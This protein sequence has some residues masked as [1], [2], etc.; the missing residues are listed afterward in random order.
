VTA[1]GDDIPPLPE[2]ARVV[3][4]GLS[5]FADAVARQGF[6]VVNVDWRIPADGDPLLVAALARL[7]GPKSERI[8]AANA[9][10]LRR[11]DSGAPKALGV[12]PATEVVPGFEGMTLLHCGPPIEYGAAIDP[13]RRSLRAAVVAEGWADDVR[14]ADRLLAGGQ[15]ALEPAIQHDACVPMVTALGP[16]QPVWVVDNAAGGNRAFAP[17]NQ[18]PG[19]TAWF[20]HD[21]DAAVERLKFLA[22]VAGR[23]L[24][25]VVRSHGP[26]DV[27]GVAGQ[28][29][30]MGD[31]VH[32]RVQAST[33][34]LLRDLLPH[35]AAIEDPGRTALAEFLAGNHLFF[36]NL[37][38]AAA[39]AL[40]GWASD[41]P[42]SSIVTTMSRNG[43]EFGVALAGSPRRHVAPAP[44]VEQAL[45]YA[46]FGPEDGAPDIGDSAVLEL[47]GLGG[48]AAAGSP[49]VAAFVGGTMADARATTE[50]LDLVC[51]GRSSRFRLPPL[52]ARGTPLGVDAR[53]VAELGIT[54]KITTGVLHA[55]AGLGQIGAGVATAPLACFVDAVLDLDRALQP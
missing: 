11:L 52:D 33:N 21:S 50:E 7:Y 2:T 31:D 5:S 46:G 53:R 38:M 51:H 26:I 12:R 1:T 3:N 23:L 44:R 54:P 32:I 49:S 4:V 24:D 48:A 42:E 36:L 27:A 40:T 13:L 9:E 20:G 15:V 41:V 47:V 6:E 19:E 30:Q 55:S 8:D 16:S 37:A 14:A 17:L 25:Q 39:R 10:V 34:L 45:Y 22:A 18:G 35:L 28:G 43:T 29:V